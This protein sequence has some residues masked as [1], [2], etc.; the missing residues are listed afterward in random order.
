MKWSGAVPPREMR[1]AMR[2][3]SKGSIQLRR[4]TRTIRGRVV[5][6]SSGGVC[7]RADESIDVGELVGQHVAV[8]LR[9]D[10]SPPSLFAL[11]GHVVRASSDTRFVAVALYD[12]TSEFEDRLRDEVV[13][14]CAYDAMP[15]VIIVD[16][17]VETRQL[18]AS[19]FRAGGC[20]VT[21]VSTPSEAI[22]ELDHGRF[23]PEVIAIADTVPESVADDLRAVIRHEHPEA[24]MVA[25]GTTAQ[26]RDPSGSWISTR[27]PK[28]DVAIRVGRVI[29]AHAARHRARCA[30]DSKFR[31]A[32]K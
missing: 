26:H 12:V 13:A 3:R 17:T 10:A 1:R 25:I 4:G 7:L 29:T 30:P 31:S 19:A 2:V 9:F 23:E 28:G 14:A 21:E 27:D 6:L 11:R 22:A 18:I 15:H 24:H 32:W 20:Q 5:D 16:A 8:A